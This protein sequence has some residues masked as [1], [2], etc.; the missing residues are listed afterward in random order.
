[1][2]SQ[3]LQIAEAMLAVFKDRDLD[4]VLTD[5]EMSP[6][7]DPAFEVHEE[8]DL[9]GGRVWSGYDG[10]RGWRAEMADRWQTVELE[11]ERW[12]ERP[13]LIVL[14]AT[15]RSTGRG[16]GV[17]VD[18]PIGQVIEF[19]EGRVRRVRYFRSHDEALEL[20]QSLDPEFANA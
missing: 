11:D 20:A 5:E 13:G 4:A 12:I 9:P 7:L 1:M 2:S 19:R 8:P 15:M 17:T 3:E 16:A 18:S 10:A 6:Y 14:L